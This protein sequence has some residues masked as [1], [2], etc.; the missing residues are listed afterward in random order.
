MTQSKIED[1]FKKVVSELNPNWESDP[2]MRETPHRL[3][4]FYMHFFRNEDPNAHMGKRFPTKNRNFV[5]VKNIEC[6]GMCPHHLTP[7]IYKIN[8][9]YL[10]EKWA[11][12][13]SKLARVAVA[14]ASSPKLQENLTSDIV[15]CVYKQLKPNGVIAT[16]EGVHGCMRCRGVEQDT[17]AVTVDYRGK[18]MNDL[19]IK[20]EFY[21]LL[22]I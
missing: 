11:L 13:L 17:S 19:K 10:P 14:C 1:A 9:G 18:K 16:V 7:V 2:D 4:R 5:I 22:K 21:T 8:I 12:G 3:G 6:F 20:N 15:D